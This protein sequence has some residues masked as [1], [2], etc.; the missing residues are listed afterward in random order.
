MKSPYDLHRQQ[1]IAQLTHGESILDMGCAYMPNR[2]L[3]GETI[4]GLDLNAME[5]NPPYTEHITGDATNISEILGQRQFDTIILGEIIEHVEQPYNLL[6]KIRVHILTGGILIISTP[7]PLGLPV[8]FAEYLSLRKFF[9]TPNHLYYF[10]PRW[11]WRLLEHSGYHVTR[12]IG[13]GV[14]LGR[15]TVPAPPTLS[16]NVI[17][18]AKP[19]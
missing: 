15:W 18:V 4:V 2:F 12:T 11:A 13:C 6:R 14:S 16:Y 10:T 8:V 1:L 5:L 7:N 9:Y 19:A 3:R 17:Y